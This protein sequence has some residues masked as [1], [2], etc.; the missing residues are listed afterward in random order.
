KIHCA[1]FHFEW[2]NVWDAAYQEYVG[3]QRD[4][5]SVAEHQQVLD[6]LR[7]MPDQYER[8]RDK[9]ILG[10]ATDLS[11]AV[12]INDSDLKNEL[13]LFKSANQ[14]RS[15]SDLLIHLE[16]LKLDEV[17]LV[18]MLE[19][20]ARAK[21][22][23]R[24]ASDIHEGI[25]RQLILDGYYVE[26]LKIV[27]S[28]H[29]LLLKDKLDIDKEDPLPAQI[30]AWYF[31]Q[32]LNTSIPKNLEAHLNRVDFTSADDFYRLIRTDYLYWLQQG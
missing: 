31:G 27:E 13:A 3:Y 18:A 9:A 21:Q 6:Q 32:R 1:N 20:S 16:R 10:S 22:R 14:L 28:K 24:D 11:V 23:Q 29:E 7:L 5:K 19:D 25:I 4:S 12:G 30:L 15:R 17:A 26:L 8:Y 2:T